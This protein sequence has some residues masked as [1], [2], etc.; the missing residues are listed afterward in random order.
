LCERIG[1]RI[2]GAA[3]L[4]VAIDVFELRRE[5]ADDAASG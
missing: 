1:V 4:G 3:G 2:V 5:L